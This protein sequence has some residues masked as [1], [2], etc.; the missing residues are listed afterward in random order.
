MF[1]IFMKM[2]IAQAGGVYYKSV[3]N[4]RIKT[5]WHDERVIIYVDGKKKCSFSVRFEGIDL[6]RR[7]IEKKGRLP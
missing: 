1:Y 5:G 2:R 6:L 7:E 3:T 4:Y